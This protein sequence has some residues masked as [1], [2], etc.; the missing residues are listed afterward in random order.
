MNPVTWWRRWWYLGDRPIDGLR[1]ED[2]ALERARRSDYRSRLCLACWQ[3]LPEGSFW[4]KECPRCG[5][6]SYPVH[7]QR[8]WNRDPRLVRLQKMLR[9]AATVLL[10]A[11]VALV[12]WFTD[13]DRAVLGIA[14]AVALFACVWFSIEKLTRELPHVWW[15]VVWAALFVALAVA[16]AVAG[17]WWAAV[18]VLALAA[19]SLWAGRLWSRWKARYLLAAFRSP[20]SAECQND[21]SWPGSGHGGGGGGPPRKRNPMT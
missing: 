21:R 20:S 19:G 2:H 9:I 4:V 1:P 16:L 5:F 14:S 11:A 12:G 15:S 13:G 17:P 6:R 7:R 8:Y 18:A 10:A 3:E